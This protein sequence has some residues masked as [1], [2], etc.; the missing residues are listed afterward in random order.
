[1][2][3]FISF[4]LF[5]FTVLP[6]SMLVWII[7]Y[8]ALD[9]SFWMSTGIAL[10]AMAILHFSIKGYRKVKFLKTHQLSRKEYAYIKKNLSE[11]KKKISRLQKALI[12]ARS[13]PAFKQNID[14]LRVTKRIYNITKREPRRFYKAEKFYFYHLDSLVELTEKYAFLKNQPKKTWELEQS[15][16][17][18]RYT[19]KDLTK[20]LEKD[21]HE[22]LAND[23]EQLNFELDVV[24]HSIKSR[25]D[26][27]SRRF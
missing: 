12:S 21:L 15:L 27:E 8:L 13:I 26:D 4:L 7:S 19:I 14:I 25:K 23:I 9:I 18:T 3:P 17:D 20:N 22:V 6:T 10:V 16:K 11:A 24:K 1:M 2:N 5:I